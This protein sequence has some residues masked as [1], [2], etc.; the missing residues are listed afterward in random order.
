MSEFR[1][2]GVAALAVAAVLGVQV[3]AGGLHYA[4][5]AVPDPC[6]PHPW[7]DTHGLTDVE[8]RVAISA[9][10]GAACD[11]HVSREDLVL[12]FA[13]DSRLES[14]RRAHHITDER[15]AEA[16][17]AGLLRAIDDAE[18]AGSLNGL[19]AA[20]LRFAADHAPTDQIIAL[21][22]RLLG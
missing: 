3:A 5:A 12:A 13:S 1:L 8:N 21:V 9:L 11:L 4:P 22:Q 20:G 2:A 17:R 7:R 10:A 6:A 14:F 16:A 19:V 18:N 15:L